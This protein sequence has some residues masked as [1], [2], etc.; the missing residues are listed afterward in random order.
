MPKSD[1]RLW[2]YE[3][4]THKK[5]RVHD[6]KCVFCKDGAGIHPGTGDAN[7]KWHGPFDSFADALRLARTQ[8]PDARPCSVCAT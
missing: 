4:W 3:N 2:V 8:Q 6:A 5:A 1:L 7:R